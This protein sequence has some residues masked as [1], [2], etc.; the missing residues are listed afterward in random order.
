MIL[1]LLKKQ[2]VVLEE[3]N[4]LQKRGGNRKEKME[5]RSFRRGYGSFGSKEGRGNREC[6]SFYE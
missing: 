4:L 6:C 1:D 5:G 3:R 2:Q